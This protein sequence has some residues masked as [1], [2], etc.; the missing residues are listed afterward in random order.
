MTR[1]KILI[2][3]IGGIILISFIAIALLD[4]KA[5]PKKDVS[6]KASPTPIAVNG[7]TNGGN[8][9]P[10]RNMLKT[11]TLKFIEN[12]IDGADVILDS[13]GVE[14]NAVQIEL[15]YD[16]TVLKDVYFTNGNFFDTPRVTV[17]DVDETGG[18]LL[19][20]VIP[21]NA[22]PKNGRAFILHMHYLYERGVKNGDLVIFQPRTGVFTA[23]VTDSV[24]KSTTN[25]FL[26]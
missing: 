22:V 8:G 16:P 4:T 13:G 3:V 2:G 7:S 20:K 1:T 11:A 24:L 23:G 19:Y 10:V 17:Y 15:S 25:L 26:R 9:T 6:A 14:V 18:H 12:T 5:P 21:D